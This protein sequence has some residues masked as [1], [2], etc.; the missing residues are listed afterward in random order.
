MTFFAQARVFIVTGKGGVGKTTLSGVMANLAARHG[1]RALV[2]GLGTPG[3]RRQP[4]V[5]LLARLFGREH[6]L[7][8]EQVMLASSAGGGEVHARALRPDTALVEYLHLHG[9]RRLSRRLVSSG[10]L[11]IVATAVPGM[12][13]ILVLGKLKQMERAAHAGSA[14]A[15]DVILLD[16]PAAGHAVRFL[17][18]PHGLLDAAAGGPVRTQAEEVVEMLTDASR[19][20]ALLVTIPEET[21]VTETVETASVLEDRAGVKLCAVVVNARFPVLAMPGSAS[22]SELGALAAAAGTSLR[23]E[24]QE[25]LAA[26]ARARR[27]RQTSEAAQVARLA[28]E[29]PLPQLELP[30]CFSA[31]LGPDQLQ[32]LTDALE[33][34][35]RR[36][37]PVAS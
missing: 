26:A 1:L 37:V 12:P 9:M 33:G 13:D 25:S 36:W 28:N 18:S 21:P 35:V 7:E 4:E 27:Q 17:Q 2:V 3:T 14:G 23:A 10:A 16:A 29:L 19:C 34:S 5:A 24:E 6:G 8:Y 30:F 20:Q 22:A 15:P 11:D 32:E 31:E